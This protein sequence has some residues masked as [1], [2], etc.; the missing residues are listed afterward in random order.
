[1]PS[2]RGVEATAMCR[3]IIITLTLSSLLLSGCGSGGSYRTNN[4]RRGNGESADGRQTLKLY[5]VD[6]DHAAVKGGAALLFREPPPG[7]E[8]GLERRCQGIFG[9]SENGFCRC[10]VKVAEPVI[11]L[12]GRRS[13]QIY[14]LISFFGKVSEDGRRATIQGGESVAVGSALRAT[15]IRFEER[16]KDRITIQA[17]IDGKPAA[18]KMHFQRQGFAPP[19]VPFPWK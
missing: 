8:F 15:E 17:W 13:E 3:L 14:T 18:Y 11:G 9:I 5:R 7:V 16:G 6:V 10:D 1:M 4:N 19:N 2:P 12:R